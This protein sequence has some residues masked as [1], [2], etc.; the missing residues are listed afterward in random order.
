M[1]QVEHADPDLARLETDP[2]FRAGLQPPIIK[3]YPILMQTIRTVSRKVALY[4]FGGRRLEKLG[5]KRQHQHSM[6]LNRKY[7]LIVEFSGE[8][9][10]ETILIVGIENHY[11]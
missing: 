4:Q 7:R 8:E 9:P 5:G 2:D 11:E 1:L 6:R 10:E 3:Q